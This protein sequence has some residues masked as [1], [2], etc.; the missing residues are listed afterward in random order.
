MHLHPPGQVSDIL[1]PTRP[2]LT[3]VCSFSL[4]FSTGGVLSLR[5][6]LRTASASRAS[7]LYYTSR[8]RSPSH[9]TTAQLWKKPLTKGDDL[10]LKLVFRTEKSAMTFQSVLADLNLG[11]PVSE[12][13]G[14]VKMEM[15]RKAC[16]GVLARVMRHHAS[17][18]Q[19]VSLTPRWLTWQL[20]LFQLQQRR[21]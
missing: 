2:V 17:Q 21:A 5:H 11:Q 19:V 3:F 4:Y 14:N 16:G 15:Y 12:L 18:T 8:R 9:F 6:P 13:R 7:D 1:P 10:F 20:T